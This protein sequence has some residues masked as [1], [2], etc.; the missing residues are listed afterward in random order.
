M[1]ECQFTFLTQPTL[2]YVV[3]A[4]LNGPRVMDHGR[5]EKKSEAYSIRFNQCP[6][7]VV[8]VFATLMKRSPSMIVTDKKSAAEVLHTRLNIG[9]G[10]MTQSRDKSRE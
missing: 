8:T 10:M 1:T 4:I 3:G 9:Q 5:D 2:R 7:G 6:V